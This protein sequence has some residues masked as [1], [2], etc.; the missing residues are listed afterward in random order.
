MANFTASYSFNSYYI[1]IT[2]VWS[3]LQVDSQCNTPIEKST[4][5]FF[6]DESAMPIARSTPD[7]TSA[8]MHDALD[9]V[10]SD[11]ERTLERTKNNHNNNKRGDKKRN[12]HAW[13][14]YI[15]II[16]EYLTF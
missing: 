9:D 15:E 11:F 1:K 10:V 5:S 3:A 16:G 2:Y 14:D 12:G 8:F 13:E 7:T 4:R 6:F